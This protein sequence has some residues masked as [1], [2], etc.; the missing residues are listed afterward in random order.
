[1]TTDEG[2]SLFFYGTLMHPAVLRRVVYGPNAHVAAQVQ[3]EKSVPAV[4]PDHTRYRVRG[5]DYPAVI[6]VKGHSHTVLGTLTT[7]LSPLAVQRLDVFEGDEYQRTPVTVLVD[8]K[9]VQTETYIWIAGEDKLEQ[10]EWDFEEFTQEK[11][12]GWADPGFEQADQVDGT[13]GRA[14][15]LQGVERSAV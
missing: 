8:G 4:L 5:C 1:M 7:N 3:I 15:H 13:G 11:L 10:R 2:Q 14:A 9:A 6:P 12:R